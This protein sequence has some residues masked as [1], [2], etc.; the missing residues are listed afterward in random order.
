MEKE[1]KARYTITT[2]TT[3]DGEFA[4]RV[5]EFMEK[6]NVSHE[7]VYRRGIEEYEKEI[8]ENS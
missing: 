4:R 6:N 7:A 8:S 1:L 2:V 5:K 3:K